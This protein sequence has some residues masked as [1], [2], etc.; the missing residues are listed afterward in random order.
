M[1]GLHNPSTLSK[2]AVWKLTNVG[3]EQGKTL[4]NHN[5][6]LGS[7]VFKSKVDHFS[8]NGLSI[9]KAS[10]R[11]GQ[12]LASKFNSFPAD[13]LRSSVLA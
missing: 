13:F 10:P 1:R 8:F 3:I 7:T 2:Q 5:A 4:D 9:A 12:L 11:V 6:P